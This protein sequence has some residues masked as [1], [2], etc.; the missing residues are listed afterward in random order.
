MPKD[1]GAEW[2]HVTVVEDG[3]KKGIAYATV[4][5]LYCDKTYSGGANRI[6][7]HLIGGDTSILKCGNVPDE[8]ACAMKVLNEGKEKKD[9]DRKIRNELDRLTKTAGSTKKPLQQTSIAASFSTGCKAAADA[10]VAQFFYAN[11]IAFSVVE[12]KYFKE[13]LSAVAKCGPSYKPPT[14]AALSGDLLSGAV[15]G[16]DKKLSEFKAQMSITGTTLI[17]DGWT[18]VQ[19]RPIINFLAVTA[20]GAMFIEGSDTSGEQKD[21]PYIAAAITTNIELLGAENVVQVVTDSAGNCAAAR[22]SLS[23]E[24]PRIVFSPCTAH[25]LDLLLEDIGKLPWAADTISKAHNMVKFLTNHQKSLACFRSHST[26]ELLKPGETRF[27]SFFIMLQRVNETKDALQET[28]M[29]REYKQWLGR[30]KK[31]AKR[32]EGTT[33]TQT[34]VDDNFWKSVEEL[35]SACEPII[36]LLRLVDGIVPCVGKVY[37]KMYQIDAGIESSAL[38]KEKKAQIRKRIKERWEML[39]T[40]LHS[41]GFVLDPEFRLFLQHENEEVMSGFHALIER[42]YKN[43]VQAQVKAI[44]QHST[45][46]AGHGLFSRPVAE[47][48]AKEMPA[49]RWWLAFGAHVPELQR[50]AVRVLSQATSASASERNWS[51]FDFI[52]TKKRNRLHCKRVS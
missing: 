12:S 5:C 6:R 18:N 25:C 20:D 17:S 7:A 32:N 9:R 43:D 10:A 29:D 42:V 31:K 21:A 15:T 16:V 14:R 38:E 33:I 23:L 47:A 41:A 30:L 44:E 8:V 45:Y 2:N 13:A 26:V 34:V 24:Y 19:N 51:T 22:A 50:V 28:V 37:W 27:A 49:F 39:H 48:A 40:D 4:H 36:V 3:G 46:R 52:H 11:G 35:I 1:K